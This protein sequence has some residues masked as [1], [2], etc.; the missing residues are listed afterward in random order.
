MSIADV[1][2]DG[3]RA[4]DRAGNSV[5]GI[6]DMN[7]DGFGDIIVGAFGYDDGLADR[8]AAYYVQG[9]FT[10]TVDLSNLATKVI[11]GAKGDDQAG[12]AVRAGGDVNNDGVPDILVSAWA[13]STADDRAGASYIL[14]GDNT[15]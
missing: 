8:G 5:D 9:P 11:M 1:R 6:G 2:M 10:G 12:H 13:E 15:W 14:F 4:Y 7:G 3:D